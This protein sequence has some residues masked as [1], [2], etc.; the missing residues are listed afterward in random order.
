MD[1]RPP[2][3]LEGH[4]VR[5]VPLAMDH[6]AGLLAVAKDPE[7]WTWV[8]YGALDTL[9]RMQEQIRRLLIDQEQGEGLCFTVVLRDTGIPI[10]M[11]R[12]LGI[13]RP[14]HSVEIGGTWYGRPYWRTAVNTESKFLLL[15]YAFETENTHRVQL[16]T[17]L[18]NLR[19][20]RAIERLGASREGVFRE[21]L[22]LETGRFRTSVFYSILISE[23]PAVKQELARKLERPSSAPV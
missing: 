13:S 1:Y 12:F 18:N 19:S 16:K 7:I 8:R 23:W 22:L 3:T 9:P 11:T 5:L 17:D 6:A 15:R 14:D 2:V 20:Q 21:H 4:H 10:G